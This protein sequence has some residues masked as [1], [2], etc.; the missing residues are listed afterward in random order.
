MPTNQQAV[1]KAKQKIDQ[2]RRDGAT[3]LDLSCEYG[4]KDSEKLTELP[5]SLDHV[6]KIRV[7]LDDEELEDLVVL[8]PQWLTNRVARVL[9]NEV[10]AD[11]ERRQVCKLAILTP[12]QRKTF[13]PEEDLPTGDGR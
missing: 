8:D 3:E 11:G 2:A 6:G 10:E 7:F 9:R 5:E 13:W 12:R 1:K 4:A